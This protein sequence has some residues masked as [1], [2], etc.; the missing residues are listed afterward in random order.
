MNSEFQ[1]F[2][3]IEVLPSGELMRASQ[4][5][6]A[7]L[8]IHPTL[9]LRN[10]LPYSMD[11]IIWQARAPFCEA[12]AQASGLRRCCAGPYSVPACICM[13]VG[14]GSDHWQVQ[15]ALCSCDQAAPAHAAAQVLPSVTAAGPC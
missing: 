2:K 8:G 15:A 1:A 9:L 6:E 14:T 4:P 12:W 3:H 13:A 10:A 7:T 5:L 11:V